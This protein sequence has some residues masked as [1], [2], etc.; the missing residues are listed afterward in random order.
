MAQDTFMRTLAAKA[1]PNDRPKTVE[2]MRRLGEYVAAD[3]LSALYKVALAFTSPDGLLALMPRL[4]SNYFRGVEL[5]GVD[6]QNRS[7]SY[8][9]RHVGYYMLGAHAQG[10]MELAYRKVGSRHPEVKCAEIERGIDD[11]KDLHFSMRW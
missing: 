8:V 3:N 1:W 10:W 4:W 9:V 7:A 2:A 6:K 5:T 11:A